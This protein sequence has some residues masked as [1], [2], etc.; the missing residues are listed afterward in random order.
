MHIKSRPIIALMYQRYQR[1]VYAW[2][3]MYLVF[4]S[5]F[6]LAFCS[7]N[8]R[9]LVP[10]PTQEEQESQGKLKQIYLHN[11]RHQTVD[12]EGRLLW[13]LQA[14]KAFV[15]Q[16]LSAAAGRQSEGGLSLVGKTVSGITNIVAYDFYYVDYDNQQPIIKLRALHGNYDQ[17]QSKLFLQ[18]RVQYKDNKNVHI[19]SEKIDYDMRKRLL[20]STK[21]VRLHKDGFYT[22]CQKGVVIDLNSG[23]QLCRSPQTN[24][25]NKF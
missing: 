23:H 19:H 12:D 25:E 4:I 6:S 22:L 11:F 9:L 15:L 24:L 13:E 1:L 20:S 5:C 21:A 17:V 3:V 18:G 14:K 8:Y 10:P 2:R 7:E 16:D